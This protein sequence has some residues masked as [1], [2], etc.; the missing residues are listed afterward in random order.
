MYT[1]TSSLS[2]WGEHAPLS[3]GR[4]V[5]AQSLLIVHAAYWT[6]RASVRMMQ[7]AASHSRNM[8]CLAGW[9][10]KRCFPEKKGG[11]GGKGASRG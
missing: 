10:C 3:G 4:G 1:S 8:A 5:Q 7:S 9:Y 11:A 6:S 2:S